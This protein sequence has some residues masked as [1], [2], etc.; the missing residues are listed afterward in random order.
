[1]VVVDV[2]APNR[3]QGISNYNA[4]SC[5]RWAQC[6]RHGIVESY[7]CSKVNIWNVNCTQATPLICDSRMDVLVKVSKFKRQKMSWPEGDSNPQPSDSCRMLYALRPESCL[8]ANF[9][10]TGR[11]RGCH[12]NNLSC[13]H[14]ITTTHSFWYDATP[15]QHTATHF[16][17]FI[18][19]KSVSTH[20]NNN[21]LT[22]KT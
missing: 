2:L 9:V 17:H 10:V 12:I 7:F 5:M 3:C 14:A 13:H 15:T 16:P 19:M 22:F 21:Q 18:K 20:F 8:D 1:M 4:D 11:T 6:S